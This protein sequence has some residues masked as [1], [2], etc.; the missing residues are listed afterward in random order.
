MISVSLSGDV[1]LDRR[2]VT[3]RA[4]DNNISITIPT[5]TMPITH[6]TNNS[7]NGIIALNGVYSLRCCCFTRLLLVVIYPPTIWGLF[8][9]LLYHS[10]KSPEKK[11]HRSVKMDKNKCP[12][13]KSAREILQK[14][15]LKNTL[16]A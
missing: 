13:F 6:T 15:P 4:I 9:I 7:G 14:T 2:E 16:L 1:F 3:S 8:T 10:L 5:T 12:F 11:W